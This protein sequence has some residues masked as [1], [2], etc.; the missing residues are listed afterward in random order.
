MIISPWFPFPAVCTLLCTY[1]ILSSNSRLAATYYDFI[2]IFNLNVIILDELSPDYEATV[3]YLGYVKTCMRISLP[4]LSLSHARALSIYLNVWL[5]MYSL[6]WRHNGRDSVS[7]HQ[8]HHCLLN[9]LFRY[10]SKKTSKLR[11]TGLY[12]GKSPGTDEFPAQ[13]ASNAENVSIWWRH[14]ESEE[15]FVSHINIWRWHPHTRTQLHTHTHTHTLT[16][17]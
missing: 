14:H 11:V 4:P 15:S 6:R 13:M 10:R 9:H 12:V 17:T 2:I 16:P 1:A 5:P 8:P 3:L 7:D